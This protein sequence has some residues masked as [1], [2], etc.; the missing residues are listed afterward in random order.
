MHAV[1]CSQHDIALPCVATHTSGFAFRLTKKLPLAIEHCGLAL[2]IL[3]HL[4]SRTQHSDPERSTLDRLL[5]DAHFN[6]GVVLYD[7]KRY[8]EAAAEL[9]HS[10]VLRPDALDCRL[11]LG[12]AVMNRALQQRW[13]MIE[14]GLGMA[15]PD[16]AEKDMIEALEVLLE[17]Q[18]L[19]P[20]EPNTYVSL[21][22]TLMGLGMSDAGTDLLKPI[23]QDAA[24]GARDPFYQHLHVDSAVA[25][26][27][28]RQL[29]SAL[30][31]GDVRW[32]IPVAQPCT[33]GR[34]G[35]VQRSAVAYLTSDS[36]SDLTDLA[37]S[38]GL[39]RSHF[40]D[41]HGMYSVIVFHD[42]LQEHHMSFLQSAFGAGCPLSFQRISLEASAPISTD[43]HFR[44][45]HQ[46]PHQGV[47]YRSMCRYF[48]GPI[49]EHEAMRGLDYYMRLDTD[50]FFLHPL[51]EDP[52]KR[53][54]DQG[55][56]Y[57]Y[58]TTATEEGSMCIGL[59]EEMT[60][61]VDRLARHAMTQ[62]RRK[63]EQWDRTFFYNNFEVTAVQ[64]WR[65][66]AYREVFQALDASGGFFSQRWGDGP[67]RSIALRLM[68]EPSKVMKL[69]RISYWHQTFVTLPRQ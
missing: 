54:R 12:Y 17:A 39:L 24:N 67:V 30:D 16:A 31:R 37:M 20:T 28:I 68:A 14:Q 62:P 60:T 35:S 11:Y 56:V 33:G 42:S 66:D 63:A 55:A 43:T 13:A 32:R 61:A 3:E 46:A 15:A 69:A 10:A 29:R 18:A 1:P 23:A 7:M 25:E 51:P 26:Q 64:F 59:E 50:S 6:K 21:A 52:F 58:L 40:F 4:S 5:A 8:A 65:S 49:F 9:R 53:V 45:F 44:Y 2:H 38:L 47:G 48:S 19:D 22:Q 27:V 41:V 57:A 36:S 34:L